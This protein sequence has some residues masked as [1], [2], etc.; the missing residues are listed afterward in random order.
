MSSK[1][2]HDTYWFISVPAEG[3]KSVV[4]EN[5][6]SKLSAPGPD[7]AEVYQFIIPE[8]KIGTLDALVV[9]SDE[10]IKYDQSFESTAFKIVDILRTLLQGDLDQVAANLIVNDKSVEQFLKTFQWDTMKFRAE[11]SLQEIAQILN[12]EVASIDNIMKNKSGHYNQIKGNLQALERKQT[13]NLAV[14]NVAEFAKKEYF[15]LDSEYLETLVVAVPKNR[16]KD[17][18]SKYETL[19]SMIVPRSSQKIAEDNDYG[20]FTVTLFKRVSDEFANKC[21]EEKFVVRDFKYDEN[22]M[23]NQ[24]KEFEEVGAVEKELA[25]ELLRLAT[26]NFG[27]VFS[28]W[29]HLKA[30]RVYVESVLRYGL[31]PD[32]MSAVIRPKFKMDKKIR[33]IL[34]NL[35]GKLDGLAYGR[36]ENENIEEYQNFIDKDYYPYVYF[37]LEFDIYKR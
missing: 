14:R 36:D 11:K 33:E 15:I 2:R 26:A 4:F 21:R 13:G 32:F 35:Y 19:A 37:H 20:L 23:E 1:H 34:N 17:W 27:E 18:N 31:P 16:Y 22:D 8:F 9:I 28:S 10:L 7:Y 12:K 3:N 30:L 5:L 29:I 6:K 25:V 24:R